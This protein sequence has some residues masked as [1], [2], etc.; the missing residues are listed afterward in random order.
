CTPNAGR[1]RASKSSGQGWV[2]ARPESAAGH[3]ERFREVSCRTEDST[4]SDT[5]R[6][7]SHVERQ[8]SLWELTRLGQSVW[9]D[10]IRRGIIDNGELARLIREDA[11][12]G[13]TSNPAIFE[14]AIARSDD[15]DQELASLAAEGVTPLAA[16]ERL[17]IGDIQR[18]ADLFRGVY[19]ASSGADGFVSLEVSPGLAH[20]SDGSLVEARRLWSAVNRPNVM[21]KIP[22]TEETLQAVEQA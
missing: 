12:R 22:G 4:M 6:P 8:G 9:L 3:R 7:T 11:V 17:A 20:D 19:E 21:I 1:A 15:Y 2:L 16:Y 10:Y 13:V 5:L 14:Q 18:A